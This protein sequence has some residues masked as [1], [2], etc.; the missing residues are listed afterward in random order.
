MDNL[1]GTRKILENDGTINKEWMASYNIERVNYY[2]MVIEV[3]SRGVPYI[4]YKYELVRKRTFWQ[5]LFLRPRKMIRGKVNRVL[6]IR[7]QSPKDF[8][9]SHVERSAKELQH[10]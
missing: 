5:K 2:G 9:L 8:L 7:A 1:I 6:I 10:A 4:F 3:D